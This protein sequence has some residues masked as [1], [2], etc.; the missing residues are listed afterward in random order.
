M[1]AHRL[2]TTS[3]V[4]GLLRIATRTVCLW[5]ECSELP[6]MK[7]G[8]HWRFRDEDISAWLK[9]HAGVQEDATLPNP[10]AWKTEKNRPILPRSG[11]R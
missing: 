5:A 6:G 8:R 4:A 7:M 11:R 10:T 9:E 3:E 1:D 2:L